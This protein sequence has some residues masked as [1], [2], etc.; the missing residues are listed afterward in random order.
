MI[1]FLKSKNVCPWEIDRP[2][3]EIYSESVTKVI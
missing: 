1:L 3:V 2:I